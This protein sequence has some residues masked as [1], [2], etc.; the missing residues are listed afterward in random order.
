MINERNFREIIDK[1]MYDYDDFTKEEYNALVL[2]VAEMFLT[3][4][5]SCKNLENKIIESLGEDKGEELIEEM[6]MIPI[7][8]DIMDGTFDPDI[9]IRIEALLATYDT[10]D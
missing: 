1:V 9:K 4:L 5:I 8:S 6:A 10:L 3:E 2:E 7:D